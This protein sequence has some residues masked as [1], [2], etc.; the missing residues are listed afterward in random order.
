LRGCV[1]LTDWS[2]YGIRTVDDVARAFGLGVAVVETCVAFHDTN[3]EAEMKQLGQQMLT[4]LDIALLLDVPH[5]AER[6][7]F[8]Q[9]LVERTMTRSDLKKILRRRENKKREG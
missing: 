6:A 8:Q 7:Q 4:F 3:T 9:E 1:L 5:V 2:K